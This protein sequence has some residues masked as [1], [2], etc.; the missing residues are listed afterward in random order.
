MKFTYN[1]TGYPQN[2]TLGKGFYRIKAWGAR[3]G[4][5][6]N[7]SSKNYGGFTEAYLR[8]TKE[9]EIS[10]IVGE[11]GR[12][13]YTESVLGGYN[14]GGN[15]F[16]GSLEYCGSSGGGATTVFMKNNDVYELLLVSGGG[17]GTSTYNSMLSSGGS[18]G[19]LSGEDAFGKKSH[20][21]QSGKQK[22]ENNGGY[23]TSGTAS[24]SGEKGTYL[25]GGDASS[26]AGAHAS[27][28]GGGYFGGGGGADTGSG[29]GGSG[30]VSQTLILHGKTEV[31]SNNCIDGN[32]L[33]I[34]ESV[35]LVT[36]KDLRSSLSIAFA[37]SLVYLS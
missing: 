34:F 28:G 23:W 22:L 16:K 18:G 37:I 31:C 25:K 8:L 13:G 3:G 30:F 1:F 29:G 15:S 33:V 20:I 21:G 7:S 11:R 35:S 19:G 36:C 24:T 5:C 4:T 2:F 9:R 12:S 6:H 27:G 26:K 32:G 17:G 14:G 10:V